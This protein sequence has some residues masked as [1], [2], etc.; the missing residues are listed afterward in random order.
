MK[1][2]FEFYPRYSSIN[3]EA[4]SEYK[5]IPANKPRVM[6]AGTP[7]ITFTDILGRNY[8]FPFRNKKQRAEISQLLNLL[9]EDSRTLRAILDSYEVRYGVYVNEKGLRKELKTAFGF[10]NNAIDSV[11]AAH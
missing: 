7:V 11:I 3:T 1:N 6:K 4:S 8:R 2:S 9:K 5:K 10:S